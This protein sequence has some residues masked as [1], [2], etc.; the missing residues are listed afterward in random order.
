MTTGRINQIIKICF[1]L[2]FCII[3]NLFYIS[4]FFKL[5]SFLSFSFF[6]KKLSFLLFFLKKNNIN[7]F[8]IIFSIKKKQSNH[9]YPSFNSFFLSH[10]LLFLHFSFSSLF[11]KTIK[12]QLSLAFFDLF[13][14]F[15]KSF[16][17]LVKIS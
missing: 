8:Q 5:K 10:N 13:F 17:G 7:L 12:S 16:C 6:K 1:F 14:I 9:L 15:C 4:I 3:T 2:F 11:S